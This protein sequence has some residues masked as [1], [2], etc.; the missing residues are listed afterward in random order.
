MSMW[1]TLNEYGGPPP[2]PNDPNVPPNKLPAKDPNPPARLG[3][4]S[5]SLK[6]SFPY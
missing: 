4:K 5:T 3:P 1:S 2:S 6:L